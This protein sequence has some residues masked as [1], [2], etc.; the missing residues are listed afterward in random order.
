LQREKNSTKDSRI[1]GFLLFL[2]LVAVIVFI[3][4]K[5][6][7]KSNE[8]N[9]T[10]IDIEKL[11]S[12]ALDDSEEVEEKKIVEVKYEIKDKPYFEVYNDWI[13]KCT[14]Y[15]VTALDRNGREQWSIPLLLNKPMLKTG[16]SG[17]L[18]VDIG[19]RNIYFIKDKNIK[20]QKAVD[21]DIIN[22]DISEDGYVTVVHKMEGYK[23]LVVLFDPEGQEIFRRYIAETFV[24]SSKV[25]PSGDQ[26]IINCLDVTGANASSYI[27]FTD[28][29]GNPFAA[30]V[31]KEGCM[32]PVLLVLNDSTFSLLDDTT[33]IC[34]DKN[35]E[36]TWENE[37]ERIY[38]GNVL[39]GKYFIIAVKD[40]SDGRSNLTDILIINKNG[41]E[42]CKQAIDGEVYN[43][44]VSS[45]HDIAA[46]NNK[47][48]V[49]FI[50]SK[51]KILGRFS[52][53]SDIQKV[54]ILSKNEVAIITKD[55]ITITEIK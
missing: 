14:I 4:Y 51:G 30:L 50:N 9:F 47:R 27:E 48:E 28:F 36:K 25:S 12:K 42:I 35:R 52:S 33:M 38:A 31:P 32:Y 37:Y 8:G 16:K 20:W 26:V 1:S 46:I 53:I 29:L 45:D 15:N 19:G 7:L 5:A 13:I 39:S 43:I 6:Y 40:D 49:I 44:F 3:A 34:Y 11:I 54:L 10:N 24:I 17:L 41:Q 22:A 55:N 2:L 23:A 21:G 18:I